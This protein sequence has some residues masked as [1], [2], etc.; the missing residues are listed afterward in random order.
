M[1]SEKL[2]DSLGDLCTVLLQHAIL[3]RVL[4]EV[5]LETIP[6]VAGHGKSVIFYLNSL[7]FS[8]RKRM[9]FGGPYIPTF[10]HKKLSRSLKIA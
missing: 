1:Q 6:R 8:F 3:T 9:G 10:E 5:K 4:N 2:P 7:S